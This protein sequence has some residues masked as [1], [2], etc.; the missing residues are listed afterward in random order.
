[1][2]TRGV[3][4]PLQ[5]VLLVAIIGL[6]AGGLFVTTGGFVEDQREEAVEHG[7]EVVG[8]RMATDIVAADRLAGSLDG[9]GSF[10]QQVE[11]PETVAGSTYVLT[12]TPIAGTDRSLL[13]L[14]S[15]EVQVTVEVEVT[16]THPVATASVDGGDL[17]IRYDAATDSLEVRDG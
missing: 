12:V 13:T 14:Q 17:A 9:S 2:D 16:T 6:L 7:L 4:M 5:Y 1:M 15:G 3:S 8:A 10:V 11:T